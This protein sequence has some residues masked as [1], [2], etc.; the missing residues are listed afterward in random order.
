MFLRTFLLGMALPAVVSGT[1]LLVTWRRRPPLAGGRW[2]GAVALSIG[3]VAGHLGIAGLPPFPPIEATQGLAYLALAA[4]MLGLVDALCRKNPAWRRWGLR[5]LLAGATV[6]LLLRSI[7]SLAWMIALSVAL[8]AFWAQLEVLAERQPGAGLPLLLL[9]VTAATSVILLVS[10]SALL[11]QLGGGLTA[12][13]AAS[14]VVAWRSPTFSLSRG[15]TPVVSVLLAGLWLNGSFYAETPLTSVALM[16]LSLTAAWV[17]QAERVQ[18]LARWQANL[19]RGGAVL[20]PL[21]LA[22]VVAFIASPLPS[23]G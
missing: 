1:V 21:V 8:L 7:L 9:V 16:A 11:G 10:G 2:S 5:L 23:F 22:V 4:M 20:I 15:A 12:A 19:V 3:Y 17:G 6:W 14:G 18:R 13:I